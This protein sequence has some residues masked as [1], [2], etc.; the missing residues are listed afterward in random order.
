MKSALVGVAS[1]MSAGADRASIF[2]RSVP[3]WLGDLDPVPTTAAPTESAP[4]ENPSGLVVGPLWD[5][6]AA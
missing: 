2:A 1:G 4:Y 5:L 3:P 6:G